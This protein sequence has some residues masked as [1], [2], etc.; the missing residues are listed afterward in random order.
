MQLHEDRN[1]IFAGYRIPH[2]LEP[3]M[4]V[5]IQTDNL[6]TPCQAME[7]ALEDLKIEFSSLLTAWL[8]KEVK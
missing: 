1:V 8:D 4:L 2:P 6:K 7:H 3:Q 5:M